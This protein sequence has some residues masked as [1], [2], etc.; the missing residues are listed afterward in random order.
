MAKHNLFLGTAAG[1]VGDVTVYR[2]DG[3]QVAR[4]RVRDVANPKST[5]QSTQRNFLAP[6]AKFFAPLAVVLA[7]SYEGLSKS[8]SY[9][10]FLKKNIDKARQNGWYL[11][12]GT[13]FF[14]LPYQVSRGTIKP[15]PY[16][17]DATG[18][19][20][21]ATA[22]DINAAP[23]TIG[24]LS[25]AF[26]SYG[27]SPGDQITIIFIAADE[28]D[29]YF[30]VYTRFILESASTAPIA[31]VIGNMLFEVAA[32]QTLL[33]YSSECLKNVAGCVIVS[34]LENGIWRRSSQSMAVDP[35][36]LLSITSESAR[37][38]AIASYG[39]SANNNDG[40]VYLDG[41]GTAYNIAAQDGAALLFVGG[42]SNFVANGDRDGEI[43]IGVVPANKNVPFFV[44]CTGKGQR[45]YMMWNS[46]VQNMAHVIFNIYE[47]DAAT[48]ANTIQI[49]SMD[50]DF[51]G[52][53][54][55]VGVP[56]AE[57]ER[58]IAMEPLNP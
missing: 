3:A 4:V 10:A 45:S 52:Y 38:A 23:T 51:V 19:G 37:K 15:V 27:Y 32:D 9:S 42:Q 35:A 54:L 11:D 14:P 58:A 1:S 39:P 29:N 33:I 18:V 16:S 30:P 40:N 24:Q 7:Q 8:K 31:D 20:K 25:Q 50:D 41:A 44:S 21:L 36:I 47:P 43:W 49:T 53:L 56:A 48:A 28:D 22:I 17:W 5:S 46:G 34:R 13:P 12:K 6:V 2:R 55:S 57:I 26:I